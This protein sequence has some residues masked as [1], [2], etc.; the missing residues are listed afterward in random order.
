MGS[1]VGL[2]PAVPRLRKA[3]P[4]Y[5]QF[6]VDLLPKP[7]YYGRNFLDEFAISTTIRAIT[8]TSLERAIAFPFSSLCVSG[9]NAVILAYEQR[10][11]GIQYGHRGT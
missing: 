1:A 2:R 9:G 5:A 4:A 11:S 6:S 8:E 10:F 3:F 7:S